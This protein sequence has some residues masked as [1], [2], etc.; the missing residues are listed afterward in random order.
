MKSRPDFVDERH[1]AW[2]IHCG[3]VLA[4]VETNLDHVPSKSI[5]DRP[6]PE[7]LPTISICRSCNTS[8]SNDEEYFIAFLG[9]VLAGTADPDHQVVERAEKALRRNLRLQDEIGTQ[10]RVEKDTAGNDRGAFV[11][12]ID[13]I[14][15]VVIKNARGHV[16]FEHGQPARGKPVHITIE[17]LQILTTEAIRSFETIDYGPGW[18]EVGSR[19]MSRLVSGEDMRADGWVIVQPNVYRF[20]VVDN[21]QFV[22]RTVIREYLATEVVWDR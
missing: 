18:P 17:P 1:K 15:N 2:C 21:G 19:L 4:S 5:L 12:D 10:F 16:L 11:P 14:R 6:F 20:A 8:F 13:R 9:S 3:E 22:V 7:N